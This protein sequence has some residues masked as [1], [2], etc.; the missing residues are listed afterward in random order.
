MQIDE[1]CRKMNVT[2]G[3]ESRERKYSIIYEM[4]RS[5]ELLAVHKDLSD[6][7]HA[8]RELELSTDASISF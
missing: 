2:F 6:L 1:F 4:E 8:Y 3:K 7:F 5:K